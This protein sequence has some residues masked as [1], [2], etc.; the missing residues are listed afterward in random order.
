MPSEIPKFH[1][2]ASVTHVCNFE[3]PCM[4]FQE[5]Y[6]ATVWW[7]RDGTMAKSCPTP[8]I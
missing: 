7:L 5:K 3:R 6:C 8:L 1:G 2:Y 4:L